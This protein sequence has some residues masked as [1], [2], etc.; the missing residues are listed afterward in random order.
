M[1]IVFSLEQIDA[2]AAKVLNQTSAKVILLNG[3]M[4]AGK[5]TFI[6]ALSRRLGVQDHTGSPTFSLVNEYQSADGKPV[7]HFDFYRIQN[8]LEALDIG[9]DDYLY[10]GNYCFIEWSEKIP[11]LIPDDHAVISLSIVSDGGR[12]LV[13]H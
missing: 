6:K 3:E 11:N 9:I 1:E 12:K 10:S 2:A 5:T 7:Y 13:L 8:E 4:G